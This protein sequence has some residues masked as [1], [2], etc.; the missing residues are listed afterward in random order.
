MK[1]VLFFLWHIALRA[2]GSVRLQFADSALISHVPLRGADCFDKS[3]S[4]LSELGCCFLIYLDLG[5]SFSVVAV[6]AGNVVAGVESRIGS[7]ARRQG[8]VTGKP[9]ICR[10]RSGEWRR[11]VVG[12][13]TVRSLAF[14]LA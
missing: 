6:Q 3:L 2:A 8:R 12:F 4:I 7:V 11:S 14:L 1:L 10:R 13:F 9:G 5:F